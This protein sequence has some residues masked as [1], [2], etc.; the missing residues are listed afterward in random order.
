MMLNIPMK[1]RK[2]Y[3][4][5]DEED[6]VRG[7]TMN[8]YS[9]LGIYNWAVAIL[10]H[11]WAGVGKYSFLPVRRHSI[12]FMVHDWIWLHPALESITSSCSGLYV[13]GSGLWQSR[14]MISQIPREIY[15]RSSLTSR[16]GER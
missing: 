8:D 6:F 15:L 3:L 12:S 4:L 11:P 2:A 7:I 9:G 14:W 5:N 16:Q 10:I 1:I 13:I